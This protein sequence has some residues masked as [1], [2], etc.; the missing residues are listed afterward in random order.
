MY[1]AVFSKKLLVLVFCICINI[2]VFG[3]Q[4]VGSEITLCSNG[5]SANGSSCASYSQNNCDSGYHDILASDAFIAPQETECRYATY[6]KQTLPDITTYLVYNGILIGSETTLCSNGYS[7]NG[8]SC[9]SYSQNN[10]DSGYYDPIGNQTSFVAPENELCRVTGYKQTVCPDTTINIVYNGILIG[11]EITLCS[12]GYST[13]GSSCTSYSNG[14]CPDDYYDL[15]NGE[16]TFTGLTAGSCGSGYKT[17]V[18]DSACGYSLSGSTCVDLC[19]NGLMTTDVGTC[20]SLCSLGVTTLRT[21]TG[22]IVP[23]WSE[24]QTT[25]SVNL[26][27]NDG[28]HSGVCYVNLVPGATEASAIMFKFD[29]TVYHT[30]N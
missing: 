18:A 30:S 2:D 24:K 29:N 8:S 13:N 14:Y 4:I 23:M 1:S 25:P 12:N 20:A 7:T 5:Y 26:G 6:K 15:N 21:S 19:V 11:S 28:Q 9:T 16:T 10:C 17:Y 27:I 22:L 3:A